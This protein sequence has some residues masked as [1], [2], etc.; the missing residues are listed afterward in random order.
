M[1]ALV[2]LFDNI[3]PGDI[4][5]REGSFSNLLRDLDPLESTKLLISC[6]FKFITR[7]GIISHSLHFAPVQ[8]LKPPGQVLLGY[9]ANP[10]RIVNDVPGWP[11]I[12]QKFSQILQDQITKLILPL[13]IDFL[14]QNFDAFRGHFF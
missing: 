2:A 4:Y 14:S 6:G 11:W 8:K 12:K 5:T 13:F 3:Y 10:Y 7:D 1:V 9:G